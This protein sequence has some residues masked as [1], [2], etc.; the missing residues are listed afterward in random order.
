[1]TDRRLHESQK[2]KKKKTLKVM[3][4]GVDVYAHFLQPSA[5][6]F[7]DVMKQIVQRIRDNRRTI[8]VAI[9]SVNQ[10]S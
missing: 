10:R 4:T 3:R 7:V 5:A 6:T 1:M 8:S 9:A 2:K